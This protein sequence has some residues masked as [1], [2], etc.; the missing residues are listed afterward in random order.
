L[1]QSV[2]IFL[3]AQI[4]AFIGGL[5][6][7]F[8]MIFFT[9]VVG[10][11]YTNSIVISGLIGAVVNFSINRN[12]TFQTKNS[13]L[14]WQL[15]KFSVVVLGSIFF[16]STGTY[17]L[18]NYL[19]IDYKITRILVDAIVSFGYNYPVQRFWVFKKNTIDT[20]EE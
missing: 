8:S 5:V 3:K 14:K 18:T 7:Y 19:E 2:F 4:S 10:I 9:E 20:T 1:I 6:D 15:T 13:N 12:W 17:L 11:F 16:K